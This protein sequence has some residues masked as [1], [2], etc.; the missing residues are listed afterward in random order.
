MEKTPRFSMPFLAPG[1]AQKEWFH[2]EALQI[3]DFLLCAVVE[4]PPQPVPPAAAAEGNCFLVAPGA[5][6]AWTGQDG[7]LAGW[8]EGG[9]RFIAPK[10]GARAMVRGSGETIVWR[11]GAW[12]CGI[13]RA[14][15]VHVGGEAVVRSR[16]PATE[17]VNTNCR[18]AFRL[19]F[20]DDEVRTNR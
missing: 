10:D 13:V 14:K 18:K 2:N 5:G 4:G 3:V 12:E 11:D 1:Q 9:W 19:T 15:E 17:R 8:C 16:Q 7:S 6:G 20:E